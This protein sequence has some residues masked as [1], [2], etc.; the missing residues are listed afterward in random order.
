MKRPDKLMMSS[1]ATDKLHACLNHTW[2]ASDYKLAPAYF[3]AFALLLELVAYRGANLPS[4]GN[5]RQAFQVWSG[6]EAAES[7]PPAG[8]LSSPVAP[9]LPPRRQ[10]IPLWDYRCVSL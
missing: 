9:A 2:T 1:A 6:R 10:L 7:L 8:D 4:L 3:D 5:R